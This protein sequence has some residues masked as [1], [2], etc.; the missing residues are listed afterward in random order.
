M[1]DIRVMN[2]QPRRYRASHPIQTSQSLHKCRLDKLE[3][4]LVFYPTY[5]KPT[6]VGRFQTEITHKCTGV[7]E[8]SK[9]AEATGDRARQPITPAGPSVFG[10]DPDRASRNVVWFLS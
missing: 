7:L 5:K 1:I 10:V 2:V 4:L 3:Y 8:F 6:I 9:V